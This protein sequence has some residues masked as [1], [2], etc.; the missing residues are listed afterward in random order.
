MK[1]WR[2]EAGQAV[3]A[4]AGIAV[5]TAAYF[6]WLHIDDATSAALT[7]LLVILVVAAWSSLRVSLVTAAVAALA[8]D[9]FFFP[10]VGTLNI[11]D[12]DDWIA[13]GAFVAVSV[14][15]SHLSSIARGRAR[16]LE[17]L[18]EFSR[19]ALL[20]GG[21]DG[22]RALTDH[23][24]RRFHLDY[25]ALCLLDGDRL[26]RFEAGRLDAGRMPDEATVRAAA[27]ALLHERDG[28]WIVPLCRGADALGVLVLAG[29]TLE[30][31]TLNALASVVAIAIERARLLDEQQQSALER[32]SVEIKSALLSSLTHDLRTPL[33][34]MT[35]AVSNLGV[36]G[37]DEVHRSR[38]A[39]IARE[40]LNRLT[41]LFDN[42]LEMARLETGAVQPARRWVHPAEVIQAARSQVEQALRDHTVAVVDRSG[43]ECVHIDPRLLATALAHL[44]EN[45]AQYSPPFSV[46]AVTHE[47]V[48]G[49]LLVTIDD[50]GCGIAASDLPHIFER[51]Y[52]GSMARQRSGTGM[53]LAIVQRLMQAQGGSVAAENR[54]RGARFTAFAPAE[55]RRIAD[56]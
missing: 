54:P 30:V 3:A 8:L 37:L 40:G 53:G 24:A 33:T 19:D 12:P 26:D 22:V 23:V 47:I 32:R 21:A 1:S 42:I 2:A 6:S 29:R 49:G 41:R 56:S 55:A 5:I 9:F 16:E 13:L 18:F 51:F 35:A 50:E 46:I 27:G 11:T 44:L 20:E 15:A 31:A 10:P 43:N 45:A 36:A 39:D 52:R 28:L 34:A 38:Q 14:V 25:V 17:R 7:Y 48:S 4:V